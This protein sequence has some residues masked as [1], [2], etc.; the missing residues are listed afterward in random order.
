MPRVSSKQPAL[1][2]PEEA[3][4]VD[5]R[6]SQRPQRLSV[7]PASVKKN[8]REPVPRAPLVPT[9]H[10]LVPL[11][12]RDDR[13]R[14]DRD[15]ERVAL[16]EGPRGDR[17][18][19]S[20]APIHEDVVGAGVEPLQG[21]AHGEMGRPK[22]VQAVDLR[23]IGDAQGDALRLLADPPGES[24]PAPGRKTLRV[25]DPLPVEA[26]PQDDGT[27]DD[28]PA[29]G[30]TAHLVDSGDAGEPLGAEL[31]LEAGRA[32]KLLAHVDEGFAVPLRA[33][34]LQRSPVGLRGSAY[35][36]VVAERFSFM[37]L[38]LKEKR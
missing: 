34:C 13:C 5:L 20:V 19:G 23:G 2:R 3:A 18:R 28:R 22:D 32:A 16:Y 10:L 38:A 37:R 35:A 11:D 7:D 25:I 15:R 14:G 9:P 31:L 8:R 21:A 1:S 4:P 33:L 12:L 6:G 36:T 27:G 24:L 26:L 30:P 17:D 29:E